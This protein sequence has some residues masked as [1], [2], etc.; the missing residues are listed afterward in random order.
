MFAES[1]GA[2]IINIRICK[3]YLVIKLDIVGADYKNQNLEYFKII[4]I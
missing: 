2:K 3:K 4:E 1:A